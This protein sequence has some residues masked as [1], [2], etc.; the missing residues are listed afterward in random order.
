MSPN[1]ILCYI[2]KPCYSQFVPENTTFAEL[3]TKILFREFGKRN[4]ITIYEISCE[5]E[6]F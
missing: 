6:V 5:M 3:I 2:N 1:I 4:K